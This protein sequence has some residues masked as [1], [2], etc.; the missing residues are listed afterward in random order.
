MGQQAEKAKDRAEAL[1]SQQPTS[2]SSS[3]S[4]SAATMMGP[5]PSSSSSSSSYDVS[6]S[7]R[8]VKRGLRITLL[9]SGEEQQ[10]AGGDDDVT[11]LSAA[12]GKGK[13]DE[14]RPKATAPTEPHPRPYGEVKRPTEEA[15]APRVVVKPGKP[16]FVMEAFS[17]ELF[18]GELT[19]DEAWE[20]TWPPVAGVVLTPP[21]R[22][23]AAEKPAL[24][25]YMR[26]G[27][28]CHD[29]PRSG[30]HLCWSRRDVGRHLGLVGDD[31]KEGLREA[32]PL[33]ELQEID[34]AMTDRWAEQ[35]SFVVRLRALVD[36]HLQKR[37]EQGVTF[38]RE[39]KQLHAEFWPPTLQVEGVSPPTTEGMTDWR[40]EPPEPAFAGKL[41]EKF[42]NL[43]MQDYPE[44]ELAPH[45]SPRAWPR[46]QTRSGALIRGNSFASGL[47]GN[48]TSLIRGW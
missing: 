25:G 18:N 29:H 1:L 46:R 11:T 42:S 28:E 12:M 14:A 27:G 16:D 39:H 45:T 34:E 2:S 7:G 13:A 22:E 10:E 26:D 17:P 5:P 40:I 24:S 15:S 43:L 30:A 32:L 6:P 19:L 8:R 20:L 47:T 44:N 4:S 37:A 36:K 48:Q 38:A 33:D 41:G 23:S 9:G 3:S 21:E 35:A 31:L